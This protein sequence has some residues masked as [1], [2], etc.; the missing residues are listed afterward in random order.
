MITAIV[1]GIIGLYLFS[2]GIIMS[3]PNFWSK[4]IFKVVPCLFGLVLMLYS[5]KHLG[6]LEKM[7]M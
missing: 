4:F 2:L 6:W 3:A 5:I 1:F 7:V